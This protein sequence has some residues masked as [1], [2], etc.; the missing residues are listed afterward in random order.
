MSPDR[1]SNPIDTINAAV[2]ALR[3]LSASPRR[4]VGLISGD[5]LNGL[6]LAL[7]PLQSAPREEIQAACD[8][9][10]LEGVSRAAKIAH[11]QGGAKRQEALVCELIVGALMGE[12]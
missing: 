8:A 4:Y 10:D 1:R 9:I 11:A 12:K 2:R 6:C 5:M 7:T 3:A